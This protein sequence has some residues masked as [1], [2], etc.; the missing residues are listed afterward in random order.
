MVQERKVFYQKLVEIVTRRRPIHN[1]SRVIHVTSIEKLPVHTLFHRDESHHILELGAGWGEFCIQWMQKHTDHEYVAF[2]L[3]GDRIKRLLKDLDRYQITGV[4]VISINFNWF[5]EQIL[6]DNTFDEIIINFPDPWPKKKHWKHRLVQ[7][8]FPDRIIGLLRN[9][10]II[11]IA[12]DYGPYAR[13]IL[14]IFRRRSDFKS[15]YAFPDYKRIRPES[16]PGTRF[17]EIHTGDGKRPYY[18]SWKKIIQN[19]EE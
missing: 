18:Q 17:E 3:K 14:G 10:G 9:E 13:K 4:S 8:S 6:P 19:P 7:E 12:T 15:L 5:L 1:D 16:F 11:H 2:E